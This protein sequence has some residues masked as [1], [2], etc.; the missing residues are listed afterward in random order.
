MKEAGDAVRGL[1]P[2]ANIRHPF[3]VLTAKDEIRVHPSEMHM[4]EGVLKTHPS[5]MYAVGVEI[6]THPGGVRGL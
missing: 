6:R 3:G 2:P 1:T 5:S 4:A